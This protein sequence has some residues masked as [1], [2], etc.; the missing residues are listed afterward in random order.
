[1]TDDERHPR[2]SEDAA[3]GIDEIKRSIEPG[4]TASPCAASAPGPRVAL[5]LVRESRGRDRIDA[6]VAVMVVARH[7]LGRRPAAAE[8]Q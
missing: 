6:N 5:G 7:S 1:M 8:A 4:T 2:S 3:P